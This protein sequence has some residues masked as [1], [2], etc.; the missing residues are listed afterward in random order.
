MNTVFLLHRP[1]ANVRGQ[2]RR[3]LYEVRPN[4]FVGTISPSVRKIL[5]EELTKLSVNADMIC[6]S[7]SE[8]GFVFQTTQEELFNFTDYDGVLLP[9]KYVRR[10][11]QKT[12]D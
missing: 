4:C 8:Q 6:R 1:P 5:W 7:N 9:T 10:E 12:T 3:Y 11:K 2:L